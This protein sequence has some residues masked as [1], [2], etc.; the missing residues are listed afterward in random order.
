MTMND[1]LNHASAA[2]VVH[3]VE[4]FEAFAGDVGINLGG[5]NVGMPQH[6]LDG[7]EICAPLQEVR[8]E[9]MAEG[10]RRE[11]LLEAGLCRLFPENIPES[12]SAEAFSGI[13]HEKNVRL[14]P[15]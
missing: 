11:R 8:R 3:F 5:G 4:F 15:L 1:F 6:R 12:L 14:F 9:R 13:V 10:M 2:G 7:P